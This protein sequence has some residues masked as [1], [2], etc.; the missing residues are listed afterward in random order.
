M[1]TK[2]KKQTISILQPVNQGKHNHQKI[3]KK[4]TTGVVKHINVFPVVDSIKANKKHLEAKL[5]NEKIFHSFQKK[6]LSDGKSSVMSYYF[7]AHI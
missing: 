1:S 7:L 3:S 5:N 4:R 6:C 2:E